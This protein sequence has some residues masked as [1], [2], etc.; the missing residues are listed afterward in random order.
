MMLP[1]QAT[2][3]QVSELRAA[4]GLHRPLPVQYLHF[5]DKPAWRFLLA[6]VVLVGVLAAPALAEG[7]DCQSAAIRAFLKDRDC[8]AAVAK[9]AQEYDRQHPHPIEL[10]PPE[11]PASTLIPQHPRRRDR[12]RRHDER[13]V[14]RPIS[15]R[16]C[17]R[18]LPRMHGKWGAGRFMCAAR[19][20][21]RTRSRPT[22]A[23]V[24][25]T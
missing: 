19:S 15:P 25:A 9:R 3:A 22:L 7:V 20:S 14:H 18:R 2:Q 11:T 1:D 17:R 23:G 12:D 6:C 5:L 21:P 13:P 4:L 10:M 16:A 24:G 8:S